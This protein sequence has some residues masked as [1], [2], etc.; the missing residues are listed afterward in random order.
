MD[1]QKTKVIFRKCKDN[2]DVIAFFPESYHDRSCNTGRIMSYLHVGQHG[3]ADIDFYR[4]LTKPA[5]ASEYADLHW[6]LS[7]VIG[8][9]LQ[10]V[11]RMR[12]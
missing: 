11:K 12:Y 5:T 3:E 9:N 1:E 4:H 7:N 2:G 8:Y 10:V 6:E